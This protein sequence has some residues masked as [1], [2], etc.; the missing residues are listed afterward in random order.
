MPIS[1]KT[2]RIGAARTPASPASATPMPNTMS[3]TRRDVDAEHLHDLLIARAGA[4]DEAV[5]RLLEEEPQRDEHARAV[6]TI[7]NRR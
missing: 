3:Q 7:R 4:D 6:T 1:G 2:P 5:G